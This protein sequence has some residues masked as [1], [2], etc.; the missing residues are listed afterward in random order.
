MKR[1]D[2]VVINGNCITVVDFKFGRPYPEHAQQVATYMQWLRMMYP[3]HTV[4]GYLWYV[5]TGQ[6]PE[7]YINN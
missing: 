3:T 7:V 4:K 1:P 5:Y 2:R 6:T